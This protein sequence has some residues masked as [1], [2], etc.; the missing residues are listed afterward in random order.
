MSNY[1]LVLKIFNIFI[2]YKCWF[3][4]SLNSLNDLKNLISLHHLNIDFSFNNIFTKWFC[5][6]KLL[7]SLFDKYNINYYM[8]DIYSK[9][10]KVMALCSSKTKQ[11]SFNNFNSFNLRKR[12]KNLSFNELFYNLRNKNKV[13]LN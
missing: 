9:N 7:N 5:K 10:S 6:Y 1:K 2:D 8:S 4:S 13:F 3:F 11:T 12:T